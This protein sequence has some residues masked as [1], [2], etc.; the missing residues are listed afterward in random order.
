MHALLVYF[1]SFSYTDLFNGS[2]MLAFKYVI[3][4]NCCGLYLPVIPSHCLSFVESACSK[5]SV[6]GKPNQFN[7][8]YTFISH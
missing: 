4:A 2:G 1:G 8:A 5:A 3:H 6:C 7:Y